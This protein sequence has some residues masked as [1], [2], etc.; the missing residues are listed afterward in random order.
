MTVPIYHALGGALVRKGRPSL[1]PLGTY[2]PVSVADVNEFESKGYGAPPADAN[3]VTWSHPTGTD[4]WSVFNSLGDNDILVLPEDEN[5]Y[6]VNQMYRTADGTANGANPT[7]DRAACRSKKGIFGLGPNA[8]ISPAAGF[9]TYAAQ[10][11]NEGVR[12]SLVENVTTGS[13]HANFTI[14][15]RNVGGLAYHALKL[16]GSD[17]AASPLVERVRTINH[18]GFQNFQ[19][20]EAFGILAQFHTGTAV[21]R[22]CEIDGRN[23]TT[24]VKEGSGGVHLVQGAAVLVDGCHV[25]GVRGHGIAHY[26][27]LGATTI[28]NSLIVDIGTGAVHGNGINAEICGANSITLNDTTIRMGSAASGNVGAHF[29]LVSVNTGSV[30]AYGATQIYANNLTHDESTVQ[31]WRGPGNYAGVPNI[32]ADADFHFSPSVPVTY[33]QFLG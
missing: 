11:A 4:L 20:G 15:G 6:V 27:R 23:P 16:D 8:I 14:R 24:G 9:P 21:I 19:P 5:P 30:G 1:I 13:Y 10:T 32:A 17:G 12:E 29:A 26:W 18:F 31:A 22:R 2:G 25:H 28:N 3:Y 33:S 7:T